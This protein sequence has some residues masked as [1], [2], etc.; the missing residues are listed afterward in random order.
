[1][2]DYRVL[3]QYLDQRGEPHFEFTTVLAESP[4][5][6]ADLITGVHSDDSNFGVVQVVLSNYASTG[7]TPEQSEAAV[8]DQKERLE[9]HTN[10]S[11]VEGS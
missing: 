1:M 10:P 7:F 2:E 6:A 8:I 4:Q 3:F 9:A 5:A 11:D